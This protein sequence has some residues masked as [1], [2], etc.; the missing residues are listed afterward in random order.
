MKKN[1]IN[2]IEKKFLTTESTLV[3]ENNKIPTVYDEKRLEYSAEEEWEKEIKV[4]IFTKYPIGK[5]KVIMFTAPSNR[6]GCTSVALRF[7]ANLVNNYQSNVLLVD[8]NLRSPSMKSIFFQEDYETLEAWTKKNGNIRN[9][10][11]FKLAGKLNVIT[12]NGFSDEN[13]KLFESNKFDELIEKSKEL[14]DFIIFDTSPISLF[15]ETKIIGKK[16]DGVIM[17]IAAGE[18]RKQVILKAK[19]DIEYINANLIGVVLNKRK[20]FIPHWIYNKL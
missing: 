2:T 13:M 3:L 15:P 4:R 7:S 16:V 11:K 14:F 9:G 5:M 19:R 12:N 6:V 1:T 18:T 10:E 20:Y 8:A 17:V